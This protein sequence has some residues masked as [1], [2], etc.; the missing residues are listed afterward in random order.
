MALPIAPLALNRNR[1][2]AAHMR[3]LPQPCGAPP[4]PGLALAFGV[5]MQIHL[6]AAAPADIRLVARVVNQGQA[7]TDLDP[8]LVEGAA[9]SRFSGRAG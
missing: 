6:T 3:D 5:S 1:H 4:D 9:A 7:L 8:A 2:C